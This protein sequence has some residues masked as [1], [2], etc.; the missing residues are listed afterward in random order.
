[1]AMS[2][3]FTKNNV[4]PTLRSVAEK[5]GVSPSLVSLALNDRPGVSAARRSEIIRLATEL[6][7][8]P[9]PAARALR[10]GGSTVYGLI[11][12]NFENPLFS[13]FLSGMQS[14]ASETNQMIVSLDSAYSTSRELLYIRNLAARRVEGL[15]IAPVGDAASVSEWRRLMPGATTVLINSD[16]LPYPGAVHVSPDGAKAVTLAFQLLI[17]QG[18]RD[19]AFLCA[20]EGLMADSVRLET[21]LTLCLEHGLRPRPFRSEL[22]FE[23]LVTTTRQLLSSGDSPTAMIANSDYACHA[24]YAACRSVGVEV[25]RG[26]SVVGHDDLATS[27][28]LDP[29]LTTLRMDRRKLGRE[30]FARLLGSVAGDHFEP[31]TLI[32]RRSTAPRTSERER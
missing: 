22:D 15:A 7:Y 31:I 27:S 6:G 13:D 11:V 4:T 10:T 28:L 32:E 3:E 26:L 16:G 29:P 14:A 23:S 2:E 8:A 19:I 25:G 24:I 1:M 17:S 20:P 18:H 30:V 9:N 5:I 21:Y 12:R